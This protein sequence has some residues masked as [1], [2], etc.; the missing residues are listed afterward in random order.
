MTCPILLVGFAFFSSKLEACRLRI[1][2]CSGLLGAYF[3]KEPCKANASYSLPHLWSPLS[4]MSQ[5]SPDKNLP[6]GP[7]LPQFTLQ[8]FYFFVPPICHSGQFWHACIVLT[9]ANAPDTLFHISFCICDH[10]P[11]FLWFWSFFFQA[12]SPLPP[13]TAASRCIPVGELAK[14]VYLWFLVF[15]FYYFYFWFCSFPSFQWC[16]Q[17]HASPWVG[18]T[19][20]NRILA[21]KSFL[22]TCLS[23]DT[24]T[25]GKLLQTLSVAQQTTFKNCPH[26]VASNKAMW[27]SSRPKL[28]LVWQWILA[29]LLSVKGGQGAI[30]AK[31]SYLKAGIFP[32]V[33]AYLG[34]ER[35]DVN[36]H[37]H[38]VL[39]ATESKKVL[40]CMQS[41]LKEW[42]VRW[43][44]L[45]ACKRHSKG[46]VCLL[47]TNAAH[48][49]R[50]WPIFLVC[51]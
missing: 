3:R 48:L 47:P 18:K 42:A 31:F 13:F 21:T 22:Q 51:Q 20:K 37:L 28:Q 9:N 1:D 24:E 41:I 14:L 2:Q 46:L 11:H 26:T 27:Q 29:V 7:G 5:V 4:S 16:Q 50:V 23:S 6:R 45:L 43:L 49:H 32:S 10:I 12:L 44:M 39:W 33:P 30:M 19:S 8:A 34:Q 15:F 35:L 38:V 25:S 36:M 40:Q 17:M